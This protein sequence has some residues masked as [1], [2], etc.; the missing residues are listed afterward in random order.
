MLKAKIN[1]LFA[2]ALLIFVSLACGLSKDSF[3][4]S[5]NNNSNSAVSMSNA[6][7]KTVSNKGDSSNDDE[8]TA[9]TSGAER[10]KPASGKGNV[11]GKVL[12]NDQPASGI[13]VRICENFSTLMGVECKGKTLTT[14][15]GSDGVF[16]LADL[17]P[18][19]YGGLTAKVFS[20]SYYVYP[21][22][23]I[24]TAQKFTVEADKTI[25]AD[26]I[27]LFKD[28]LKTTNP[29]AGAKADAKNLEL[30]WNAYPD[31]A[32]YKV[33]LFPDAGGLAPVSNERTDDPTYT[34]TENLPNGKY[35]LKVVAYNAK[36][37]KLAENSD[38]IKFTVTGGAEPEPTK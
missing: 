11:Q 27:N 12:Y 10:A 16:V 38:D 1:F 30:K 14:K 20:T 13:E 32:Y 26:D 17:E 18:K 19:T 6:K 21:Q 36:D 8:E 37:H 9:S 3:K 31:A 5:A 15:T 34:V 33:S 24:M 23:G 25:F 7:T 29:K 4:D 28:D 22:E 35:S 2:V